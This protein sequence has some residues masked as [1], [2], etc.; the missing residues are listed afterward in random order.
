MILRVGSFVGPEGQ[1]LG[2]AVAVADT[3]QG[4]DFIER[5]TRPAYYKTTEVGV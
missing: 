3:H 2:V 4:L 5:Y 1:F